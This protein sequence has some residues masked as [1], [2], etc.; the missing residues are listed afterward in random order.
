[1]NDLAIIGIGNLYR[2]DDA[3]GWAVIEGLKDRIVNS[4][5]LLKV[6]GDA[7]ELLDLFTQYKTVYLVDACQ[8]KAPPGSWQRIDLLI[9][10]IP[11]ENP[12]TSTHGFGV[13][14]AVALAKTLEQ[15]PAKLILYAICGNDYKIGSALTPSVERSVTRVISEIL[16]EKDIQACMNRVS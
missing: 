2:S 11:E 12:Q 7:A 1:M 14:Q 9:Q 4:I 6:R 16:Q 8:I 10:P 15:L 13:S 5:K 3:A